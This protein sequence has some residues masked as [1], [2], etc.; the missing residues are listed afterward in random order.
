MKISNET[1]IGA[2]T[3][4]AITILILGFNFL[5]GKSLSTSKNILY[6]VFPGVEGLQPSNAVYING[7]QVGK[8]SDLVE[9]DKNL[10]GIIVTIRLSKDI[11][12]PDNSIAAIVSDLLG[13]SSIKITLGNS[14]TY[15]KSGDTIL[16]SKT[17][18]L[19]D[20]LQNS[21]DP[22]LNNLNKTLVSLEDLI[23]RVSSIFDP[24][25]KTNLQSLIANLTASSKE[26]NQLLNS[27]SGMLAKSLNNVENFTGNLAQNNEK[28]SSTLD[29][30][31]KTSANLA[32]A[33]IPETVASLQ[34]TIDQLQATLGK[35]N[36]RDGT[37]GQLLNDRQLYDHLNQTVRSLNIL[38]D[39]V[40]VH[41]KRYVN[42]SV[43]GRKD[44]SGPLTTPLYDSTSG[45]KK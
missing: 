15:L 42:I 33:K 13:G 11:N 25:A 10:S 1:K 29:N 22:T 16:T 26:L 6:G 9:K 31:Q 32:G 38:L 36:N 17:F 8:V 4:I 39:D 34:Q 24:A 20:R 21:L 40:R 18:G 14:T 27:Q 43:F 3:A 44:K 7:L 23:T 2:L 19:V 45:Q 12:I 30:L 5:K 37:M 28:I 41:P 35:F